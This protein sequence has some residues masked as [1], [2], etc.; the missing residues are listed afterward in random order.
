LYKGEDRT[1]YGV[2]DSGVKV[3][4]SP[5]LY[6]TLHYTNVNY[7][8][9]LRKAA[10]TFQRGRVRG[11]PRICSENPDAL[12]LPLDNHRELRHLA[13]KFNTTSQTSG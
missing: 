12:I 11:L 3:W 2:S 13:S 8:D 5:Q 10:E 7:P 6:P 1:N 4:K 9:F